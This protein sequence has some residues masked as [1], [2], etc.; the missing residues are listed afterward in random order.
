MPPAPLLHK[1]ICGAQFECQTAVAPDQNLRLNVT[2][3][4]APPL[5]AASSTNSSPASADAA[6]NSLQAHFGD[7]SL[8]PVVDMLMSSAP[9]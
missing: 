2:R 7:L 8:R 3:C 4:V 6:R 1:H 5:T 9:L